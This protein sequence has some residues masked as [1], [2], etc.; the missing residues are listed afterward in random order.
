MVILN[1]S[2]WI[3][4]FCLCLSVLACGSGGSTSDGP[5]ATKTLTA[6]SGVVAI[7]A[8]LSQGQVQLRQADGSVTTVQLSPSGQ[9]TLDLTQNLTLP[10]VL[11]A[12]GWV[13]GERLVL[14]SLLT[15]E[16][17]HVNLTP[18]TDAIAQTVAGMDVLQSYMDDGGNVL[19]GVTT[20]AV[21]DAQANLH[22]TL[23]PILRKLSLP[24]NVNFFTDTMVADG[25]GLDALYDFVKFSVL[26][27]S[28]T[29]RVMAVRT[30]YDADWTAVDS[31]LTSDLL[32]LSDDYDARL[33]TRI[34]ELVRNYL[35]LNQAT[36]LDFAALGELFHADFSENG[37]GKSRY[38]DPINYRSRTV[39]SIDVVVT[40]CRTNAAGL[41]CDV[42][43]GLQQ[44]TEI[45]SWKTKVVSSVAGL[46]FYGNHNGV[47]VPI[48]KEGANGSSVGGALTYS[49][50]KLYLTSTVIPYDKD[51]YIP[52]QFKLEGNG[53]V[54]AVS[55][56]M[57]IKGRGNLS[58]L[59][60]KKPWAVKF[61]TA[62]SLFGLTA[63]KNWVLL[64]NYFDDDLM[65]NVSAMQ[66]ARMVG[67]SF[68][69]NMNPVELWFN[70]EY[71][72]FY[73][74]TEKVEINPGRV[75]LNGGYILE[76]SN[77]YDSSEQWRSPRF[78]N[79]LNDGLPIMVSDRG[80]GAKIKD[81]TLAAIQS[82]FNALETA[83]LAYQPP[84]NSGDRSALSQVLDLD[85]TAQYLAVNLILTN[86]EV[87]LPKSVKLYKD[88]DKR[89]YLG[90]PWD[91]DLAMRSGNGS[92]INFPLDGKSVF[93]LP[94]I[95]LLRKHPDVSSRMC[96]AFIK[97]K[98]NMVLMDEFLN[99]YAYAVQDAYIRNYIAWHSEGVPTMREKS[100]LAYLPK[101]K[102]YYR[103]RVDYLIGR[104]NCS[105]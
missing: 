65:T 46:Q 51:T 105:Q 27:P 10:V 103:G 22:E 45:R 28:E 33:F 38:L 100:V 64:A 21:N 66:V 69:N 15:E 90:P 79:L 49:V 74:L 25:T 20:Q 5:D 12:N 59:Q 82:Q 30:I 26:T 6:L 16:A 54:D 93:S 78:K 68:V 2:R 86:A 76:L 88:K 72:G 41:V 35:R 57:S 11:R 77:E 56:S 32:S 94:F 43:L 48:V 17:T 44:G 47:M 36:S 40:S 37:Y 87:N 67:M 60:P 99:A 7:G 14:Y 89:F 31:A 9:W 70:G 63:A 97:F 18:A 62:Q 52:G 19:T 101:V 95:E 104:Y 1:C 55:A 83:I 42:S 34:S 80:T 85:S 102:A 23:A 8:P 13:G 84:F 58:W 75:D 92:P 71:Q 29:S 4:V 91:F 81:I 3:L 73:L 24:S 50:P 53:F 39:S 96:D 98:Y 61:D